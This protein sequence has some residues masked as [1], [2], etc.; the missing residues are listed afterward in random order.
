MRGGLRRT[1]LTPGSPP[2]RGWRHPGEISARSRLAVPISA[3]SRLHLPSS[4]LPSRCSCMPEI[5]EQCFMPD[6]RRQVRA[7]KAGCLPSERAACTHSWNA[8][9]HASPPRPGHVVEVS[10]ALQPAR[11]WG[12]STAAQKVAGVRSFGCHHS[13]CSSDSDTLPRH[14]REPSEPCAVPPAASAAPGTSAPA[15][16]S[17]ASARRGASSPRSGSGAPSPRPPPRRS[18]SSAPR[19]VRCPRRPRPTLARTACGRVADAS[20][21][22]AAWRWGAAV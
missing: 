14:F 10:A 6:S 5:H 11:G 18:G 1:R 15:R 21:D 17:S 9:R 22:T 3:A 2:P 16:A 7:Q 8:C 20:L 12:T 13:A 19:P 4:S